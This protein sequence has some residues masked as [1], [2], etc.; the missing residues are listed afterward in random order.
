[1]C[2]STCVSR[3]YVKRINEINYLINEENVAALH[4][5]QSSNNKPTIKKKRK[6]RRAKKITFK[7]QSDSRKKKFR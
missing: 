4:V 3:A 5:L 1:M 2:T 6:K 7:E